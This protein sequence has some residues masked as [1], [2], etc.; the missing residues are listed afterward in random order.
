MRKRRLVLSWNI[1][2]RN[3]RVPMERV[4]VYLDY[5][6]S[7]LGRYVE[8]P[9]DEKRR[10]ALPFGRTPMTWAL[11]YTYFRQ[12]V[13]RPVLSILTRIQLFP[14][15]QSCRQMSDIFSRQAFGH[16]AHISKHFLAKYARV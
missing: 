3:I 10:D 11:K 1:R 13:D 16:K 2:S 4:A 12:S 5:L 14:D 7:D 8:Y 6:E 9:T 15:M